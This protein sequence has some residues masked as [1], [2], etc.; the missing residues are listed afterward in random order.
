[1]DREASSHPNVEEDFDAGL[2][3]EDAV[4]VC[5]AASQPHWAVCLWLRCLF[6]FY[7]RRLLHPLCICQQ[8]SVR[9]ASVIDYTQPCCFFCFASLWNVLSIL[10]LYLHPRCACH[11]YFQ[12]LW[13]FWKESSR[14]TDLTVATRRR[15]SAT[16]RAMEYMYFTIDPAL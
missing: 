16:C 3:A 14:W 7:L 13:F 4:H 8:I 10:H 2:T 6:F 15:P 5:R 12:N 9:G 1:M 11:F